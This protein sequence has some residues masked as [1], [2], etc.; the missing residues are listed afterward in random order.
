M[1]VNLEGQIFSKQNSSEGLNILKHKEY[2][3]NKWFLFN[4]FSL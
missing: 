2:I 4:M 3:K 1:N